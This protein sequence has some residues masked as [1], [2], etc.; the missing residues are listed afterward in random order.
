MLR[1]FSLFACFALALACGE[2]APTEEAS[3]PEAPVAKVELTDS[4]K[5]AA[6]PAKASSKGSASDPLVQTR[7]LPP[8]DLA[9]VF[10]NN[11]D[12]E[13]EPCG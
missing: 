1:R 4:V 5:P 11:V 13:I 12:G 7:E 3:E 8:G 9:F 6:K 10:T 2:P